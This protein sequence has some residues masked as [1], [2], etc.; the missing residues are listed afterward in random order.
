MSDND[1]YKIGISILDSDYLNLGDELLKIKKSGVDFIH[2]DVMDGNFVPQTAF[3][4][5]MVSH[6]VKLSLIHI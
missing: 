1:I 6:L 5:I 2:L 3:G 4:Q